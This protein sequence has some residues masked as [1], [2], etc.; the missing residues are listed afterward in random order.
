MWKEFNDFQYVMPSSVNKV[1]FKPTEYKNRCDL[2]LSNIS[3]GQ[4]MS[5]G[6]DYD[7]IQSHLS[8]IK[9]NILMRQSRLSSLD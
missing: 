3:K 1:L 9:M 2:I 7:L 4:I 8:Y 6:E 5:S